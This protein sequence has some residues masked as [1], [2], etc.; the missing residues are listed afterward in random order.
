MVG[1]ISNLAPFLNYLRRRSPAPPFPPDSR[2]AG[3]Q[4]AKIVKRDTRV[5]WEIRYSG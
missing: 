3:E 4:G 5:D 1:F 2:Q